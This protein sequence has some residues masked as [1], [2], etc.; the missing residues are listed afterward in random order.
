MTSTRAAIVDAGLVR[1]IVKVDPNDLPDLA[2][3][4]LVPDGVP[5]AIGWS[6]AAGAFAPPSAST[7]DLKAA[8]A[9][10]RWSVETGGIVVAGMSIDTGRESQ[11]LIAGAHAYVQAA[12]ATVIPFKGLGGWVDLDAAAVTAVALAVAA[13]VQACFA[14]ERAVDAAIDAGTISTVAEIDAADW[15][16]NG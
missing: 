9:A 3:L 7:P 1:N 11:A 8:A 6:F 15:P 4:H 10:K 5:V 14:A 13:H 12:P 16:Q 2:G